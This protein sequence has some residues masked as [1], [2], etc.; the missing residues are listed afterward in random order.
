MTPTA[1]EPQTVNEDG[2]AP[3]NRLYTYEGLYSAYNQ[4]LDDAKLNDIRFTSLRGI[5]DR[6]PPENP[7]SLRAQGL[8]DMP[9]FNDGTFTAKVDAYVSTLVDHDTGG[10]KLATVKLK[11]KKD[12]PPE[13]SDQYDTKAT[14]FFNEAFTEWDDEVET[15]GLAEYLVKSI[16]R[17]KQMSIYGVGYSYFRDDTDW[18]FDF[19]PTRQFLVPHGTNITLDNCEAAFIRTEMTVTKLYKIVKRAP[20]NGDWNKKA[21]WKMLYERTSEDKNGQKE[22]FSDWQNRVRDNDTFIRS[23][24]N[25]VLLVDCY[26]QEFSREGGKSGVSHAIIPRNASPTEVLYFKDR[27]YKSFRSFVVPFCDDPGPE[28]RLNGVKGF[29]DSIFDSCHAQN[30]LFNHTMRAGLIGSMPMFK[31]DS[32][33]DRDKLSQIKWTNLGILNPG[34]NLE[35]VKVQMDLNGLLAI[36]AASQRTMNIN[37]RTYQPGESMGQQAK[38]ATQS[39]FDRQDQ[40]KLST[41]QIKSYRV[42]GLDCLFSEMYRRLSRPNYSKAAPGG[43]AAENFRKK[44]EEAGIPKECYSEPIEVIADRTGGSGNQALDLMVAKEVLAI[45]SV[46]R[47]QLNAR[48]GIAKVLVGPDRVEEF[49]QSEELPQN[50]QGNV[51]LENSCLADGQTFKAEPFQEHLVHLGEIAPEGQGHFGVLLTAYQQASQMAQAGAIENALEDAKTL[52]R[53]LE[54]TLGHVAMHVQFLGQFQ[55]KQY[56]EI[57][58]DMNKVVNDMSQFLQTFRQQIGAAIEKQQPQGPQMSAKDQATLITA[59]VDARVAE[60]MAEQKLRHKEQDHLQKMG[61]MAE[62][63]AGKQEI[64][65]TE[66]QRKAAMEEVEFNRKMG[67][68]AVETLTERE[69]AVAEAQTRAQSN[70]EQVTE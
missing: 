28:G 30:Q 41:L 49:V 21:V 61:N 68:M 66:A 65:L 24:F 64:Q 19:L 32:E 53:A 2:K 16:V 20:D 40:A 48:R 17:N 8:E 27:R 4:A 47:G 31:A 51:N 59:Q 15:R 1:T 25:E 23:N 36:H 42:M 11:R 45:A 33:A 34:I 12:N 9:N 37:T 6:L 3:K 38:T 50:E 54:A 67:Q 46:G 22:T 55:I 35:Q 44:C 5:Y 52:D 18:R 57:A 63:S 26:I 29:G 39:T 10:Y 60:A 62:R 56:Q 43:R 70:A 14:E 7:E 58:K 13:V 69:I